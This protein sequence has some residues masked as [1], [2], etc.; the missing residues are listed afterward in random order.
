M[1]GCLVLHGACWVEQALATA[2]HLAVQHELLQC[3]RGWECFTVFELPGVAWGWRGGGVGWVGWGGLLRPAHRSR[4]CGTLRL[5]AFQN[6]LLHFHAGELLAPE[7]Y[8]F[9]CAMQCFPRDTFLLCTL[10]RRERVPG[11]PALG[12]WCILWNRNCLCPISPAHFAVPLYLKTQ[13]PSLSCHGGV[14]A[15]PS[16]R[17]V[18]H[19][20]QI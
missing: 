3:V 16:Q 13:L 6:C 10:L 20:R 12:L 15:G 17:V 14:P 18:G 2:G 5:A 11:L 4:T 7:M 1:S 9:C 19:S 8:P